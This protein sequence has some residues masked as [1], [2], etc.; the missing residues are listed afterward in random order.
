MYLTP[1]ELKGFFATLSNRFDKL[2][3]LMDCYTTFAARASKI[4]NPINDVG[5]TTVY[6]LDDPTLPLPSDIRFISEHEMT[7]VHLMDELKGIEKIIFSKV[8]GGKMSNKLY[9]LYEY[10]K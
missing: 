3:I 1:E 7:P 6:G 8:Y 5:V 10:S 9:K 4:K 2:T